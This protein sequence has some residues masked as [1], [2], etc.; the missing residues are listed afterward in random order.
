MHSISYISLLLITQLV[1]E[2]GWDGGGGGGEGIGGTQRSTYDFGHVSVA[3]LMNN[4]QGP[5]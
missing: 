1:S 3:E 2:H 5:R 4:K